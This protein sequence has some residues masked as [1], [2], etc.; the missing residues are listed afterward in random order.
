[1]GDRIEILFNT[2]TILNY[3]RERQY[4]VMVGEQLFSKR[5]IQDLSFEY[6]KG[7]NNLPVMASVHV[8]KQGVRQGIILRDEMME[9]EYMK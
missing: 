3:F 7:A 4:P 8:F 1:M 5:K 9:M 2:N 6:L